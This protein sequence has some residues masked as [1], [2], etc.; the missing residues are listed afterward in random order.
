[1]SGPRLKLEWIL[2]W[3]KITLCIHYYF[4][5]LSVYYNKVH[6]MLKIAETPKLG[7]VTVSEH[8][9]KHFSK[10][11]DGDM[12]K[13]IIDAK[14]LLQSPSIERLEV[15]EE[16]TSLMVTTGDDPTC[17]EFWVHRESSTMLLVTPQD[18]YKFVEMAMKQ[19]MSDIK[20][21]NC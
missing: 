2:L 12:D 14:K 13:A 16:I 11:C 19:D 5:R 18:N 8:V 1:M 10:L 6:K 21:E 15:P 4:L 9:V 3:I 7:P 17:L 20:F